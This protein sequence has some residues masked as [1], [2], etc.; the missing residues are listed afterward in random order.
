MSKKCKC[1]RLGA[2]E[3]VMT[4]G[5]MMTLLLTF[6]IM[7]VALS[8]IKEEDE[9]KAIVDSVQQAFGMKSGGGRVVTPE[10]PEL[11][12]PT[13]SLVQKLEQE[14]KDN[15]SDSDD[16]GM[17][18]KQTTVKTVKAANKFVVGGRITF[19]P[20]DTRLS[21]ESRRQLDQVVELVR[22]YN[23]IIELRG[24]AASGEL[25]SDSR[26]ATLWKLSFARAESVM[27]YLSSDQVGIRTERIRLIGCGD[28][29]RV[30][31]RKYKDNQQGANRRVEVVVTDVLVEDLNQPET[32]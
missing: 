25:Q 18:G 24:H 23:N 9:F 2:P 20:G 1:P 13:I 27:D 32:G 7:L 6:F 10:D 15:R 4:Y 3:W 19:E 28:N 26:F 29:E 17:E 8:E 5:D 11:S 14:T 22:G 12:L 30:V 16:P 31:Y 21:S